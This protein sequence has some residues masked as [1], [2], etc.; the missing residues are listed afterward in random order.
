MAERQTGQ[1]EKFFR[2]AVALD[3]DFANAHSNL[4]VI[5]FQKKQYR[6]AVKSAARAKELGMD[7]ENLSRSLEKYREP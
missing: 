6:L 2:Q 5:Y 1:A 4:A 3:P 7:N